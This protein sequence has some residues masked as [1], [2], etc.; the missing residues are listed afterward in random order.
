MMYS[1]TIVSPLH[2]SFCSVY[3]LNYFP[4]P[5]QSDIRFQLTTGEKSAGLVSGVISWLISGFSIED[6]QYSLLKDARRWRH[7]NAAERSA[8]EDQ[9]ARLERKIMTFHE[10][11]EMYMDIPEEDQTSMATTLMDEWDDLDDDDEVT[12]EEATSNDEMMY[13]K[14][15][16]KETRLKVTIEGDSEGVCAEKL[17][18]MLPST[19][20]RAKINKLGLQVLASQEIQLRQGQ[21]NDALAALRL[22]LGYKALLFRSDVR[23]SKDT[24][25]KTRAWGKV[26]RSSREVQKH[27]LC[28]K[29]A[30]KALQS[31]G[32][33]SEILDKYKEIGDEDLKVNSDMVEENRFGQRNYKLAWFWRLGPEVQSDTVDDGWMEE[34]E[35]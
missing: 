27:L 19:L 21:A 13:S 14:R 17:L 28:Y 10:S 23:N 26:R 4:A 12:D 18:L 32:A 31:L 15:A 34:C 29:R 22:E 1:R 2:V 25:G 6:L 24:K 30:R 16:G 20:G 3:S 8:I 33:S 11:M 9:R 35:W 7:L 5:T